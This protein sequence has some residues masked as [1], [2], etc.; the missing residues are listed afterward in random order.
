MS[1]F[2]VDWTAVGLPAKGNLTGPACGGLLGLPSCSRE[3]FFRDFGKRHPVY[4]PYT[5]VVYSNV[6]ITLLGFV[7]ETVSGRPFAEYIRDAV[8]G[9]LGLNSTTTGSEPVDDSRAFIPESTPENPTWW[10]A[11]MGHPN[12]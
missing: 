8:T 10:G 2:P 9:P 6:G 3:E 4:A 5:T 1:S 7:L 12:L 11:D